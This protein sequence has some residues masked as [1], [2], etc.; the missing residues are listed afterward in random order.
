MTEIILIY[1][2]VLKVSDCPNTNVATL[3][4]LE[5]F[6]LCGL[7]KITRIFGIKNEL[8]TLRFECQIY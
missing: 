1:S 7:T 8:Q 3:T 2:T 5:K 6:S 4:K